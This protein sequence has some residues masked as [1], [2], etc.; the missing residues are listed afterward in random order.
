MRTV[1]HHFR[2]YGLI[3]PLLIGLW[4]LSSRFGTAFFT[5]VE[6]TPLEGEVLLVFFDVIIVFALGFL[7]SELARPTIIPSFVLAIFFGM[8][9]REILSPLVEH[10]AVLSTLATIG[11]MLILFG[12]GLDTPFSRFKQLLWPSMSLAIPGSLIQA[13]LTSVIFLPLSAVFGFPLTLAGATLLGAA[14]TSTDPA[15]IIPSLRSLVFLNSRPKH[16]AVIE[17]AITDVTGIVLTG[18]FLIILQSGTQFTSVTDAYASLLNQENFV[19]ILRVLVVGTIAGVA[20]FLLLH[21]WSRLKEKQ[22]NVGESDPAMFLA[23]PFAAYGMAVMFGGSG[24]LAAFLVGL[25]FQIRSHFRHVEHYF[26]HTIEGFFKPMIF[27][28]LGALVEPA[29]LFA[30]APAGI[31]AFAAFALLRPAVVL[32]T[33]LPFRFTKDR[34]NFREFAFLSVIR[35]TGVIPA[36][37]LMTIGVSGIEGSD[38]IAA[39]GL[40]V[41]LLSLV[42]L[43]P[44]TPVIARL[45]GIAKNTPPFPQRTPRGPVAVLC[46]RG[47]SFLERLGTVSQWAADHNIERVLLLHCPEDRFS[48]SF[49]REVEGLADVRFAAINADLVAKGKHEIGFEFLGRPGLL[50]ENIQDLVQNDGQVS[51]IFVGK[52]MLDFRL[53][54]V[55]ELRVPFVF[56]E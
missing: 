21:G 35:E 8:A 51:I 9:G 33:L 7:V 46:S 3:V 4:F 28:L 43:P 25:L 42:I 32:V 41:I 11:A 29:D 24:Y 49:L 13:F 55:K 45:L 19:Y 12:G 23:V 20:G 26:N 36:V 38:R 17:S 52:K 31:A 54:D 27:M 39:I 56:L 18:V 15:S 40:W 10:H 1:V 2:N 47:Y 14:L 30:Y 37:L 5:R 6:A 48:D 53:G 16:I 22:L 50:Q 44:I 34:M